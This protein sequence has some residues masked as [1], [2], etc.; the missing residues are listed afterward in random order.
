MQARRSDYTM[1]VR[2]DW[3]TQERGGDCR[4]GARVMES[5][6][7]RIATSSSPAQAQAIGRLGSG[8]AGF[9][10]V[11]VYF[12]GG[13]RRNSNNLRSSTWPKVRESVIL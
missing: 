7:Q 8:V 9:G 6:E 2:G 4:S 3:L 13:V 11:K 10:R 5:G 1:L 12:R